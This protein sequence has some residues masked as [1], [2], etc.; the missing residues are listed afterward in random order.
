MVRRKELWAAFRATPDLD[1]FKAVMFLEIFT[2][3]KKSFPPHAIFPRAAF[4]TDSY[5]PYHKQ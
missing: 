2:G 1:K 4:H 5:L 3:R